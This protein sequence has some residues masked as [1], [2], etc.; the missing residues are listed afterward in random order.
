[1][2]EPYP[3]KW[4]LMEMPGNIA[5]VPPSTGSDMAW[6]E[7]YLLY[8]DSIFIKSR[9]EKNVITEETGR[10]A[11]VTLSD[12]KYLELIYELNNDQIGNCT[13]EAKELLKLATENKLIGTWWA[14]DGPGLVYERTK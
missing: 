3:Q 14:C 7:Y 1:M 8:S 5:D 2:D 13:S 4:Q 11:F 6:Q 10:F 9:E 12:G